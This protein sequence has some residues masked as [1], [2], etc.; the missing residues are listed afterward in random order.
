[1]KTI[2][3]LLLIAILLNLNGCMTSAS[4]QRAKGY[5]TELVDPV[6]GD[7]YFI[8][9]G[10]TYIV[11]HKPGAGETNS[12]LALPHNVHRPYFAYKPNLGYY[13]LLP[14]TIPADITLSPFELIFYG[15]IGLAMENGRT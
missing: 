15:A 14:L 11:Q 6:N 3:S 4:I 10:I 2:R 9:G 7:T 12:T 1:M 13:F 5:T 8:H